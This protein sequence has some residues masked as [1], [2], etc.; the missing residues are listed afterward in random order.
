MDLEQIWGCLPELIW[1]FVPTSHTKP[2]LFSLPWN[3]R[4]TTRHLFQTESNRLNVGVRDMLESERSFERQNFFFKS[5]WQ[6]LER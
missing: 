6:D 5:L 4:L 1:N 2:P 3:L